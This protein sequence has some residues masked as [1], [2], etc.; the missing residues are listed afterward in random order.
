MS[1]KMFLTQEQAKIR[2]NSENNLANKFSKIEPVRATF[3][4][5]SSDQVSEELAKEPTEEPLNSISSTQH[6]VTEK[7]ITL[8]GKNRIN[9]T[10][11]ERTNI[12]LESRLGTETQLELARA[13]DI[14]PLAVHNIHTG[15]VKGIDEA[16]VER[17]INSVKDRALDRLMAS[18]GLLNDDKLSGC[19]AKD[20]SVIASNMGRVV[21]KIQPKE[22]QADNI[23]FIIYAPELKQERAYETVEV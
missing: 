17:M 2:L 1:T 13:H 18:L 16:R 20:L 23:N 3:N 14:T 10:K 12:A 5:S 8:P 21:E 9:L 7:V 22:I 11:E 15:K 4:P 19:S 6:T